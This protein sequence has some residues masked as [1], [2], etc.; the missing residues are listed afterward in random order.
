MHRP[1]ELRHHEPT[2]DV[3]KLQV[4]GDLDLASAPSLRQL[5]GD[6]MGAGVRHVDVDL[7]STEF[8]DSTGLGALL[9]ADHRLQAAG[10]DLSLRNADGP[11]ARIFALAGLD[12]LLVH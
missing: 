9:W 6:L 4:V 7:S 2:P 11:V 8:V 12:S 10:G 1:F 5:L 3:T